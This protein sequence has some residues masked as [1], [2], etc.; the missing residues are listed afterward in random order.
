MGRAAFMYILR[1]PAWTR[2]RFGSTKARS[3]RSR[4]RFVGFEID[5]PRAI[6]DHLKAGPIVRLGF[7][8]KLLYEIQLRLAKGFANLQTGSLMLVEKTH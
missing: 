3:N 6:S 2:F 7:V 1:D 4:L 5:S 8:P